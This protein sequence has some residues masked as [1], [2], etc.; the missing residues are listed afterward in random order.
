MVQ[1]SCRVTNV[2][3]LAR[4]IFALEFLSSNIARSATP[5]QF[6]NIKIDRAAFP[7]WRRP[8]SICD[9]ERETVRILFNVVGRGTAVLARTN[10][11][12]SVDVVGPLGHGFDTERHFDLGVVVAGGLGVAPFSFL[13]RVL[14]RKKIPIITFVGARTTEYLVLEGLKEVSVATDDGSRGYRGSVVDLLRTQFGKLRGSNP[15]LFT[16]GPTPM[17]RSLQKLIGEENIPCQ[18]SVETTMACG[19]GLCQGC[20]IEM[21][22]GPRKYKLACKDGPVFDLSKIIL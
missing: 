3:E 1:E 14:S 4:N 12:E 18:A 10:P 22:D 8:M 13:T 9:A 16:C 7:L 5:G 21:A 2:K 19:I 20:P 17:F 11:G 15:I 6:V